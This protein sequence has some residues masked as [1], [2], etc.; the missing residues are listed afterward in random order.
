MT[1][2]WL[3]RLNDLISPLLM[4]AVL[5]LGLWLSQLFPIQWDW[6][7]RGNNSLSATSIA[8]LKRTT[9]PIDIRV[10]VAEHPGLHAQI[11]RFLQRYQQHKP[12]LTFHFVDPARH[13]NEARRQGISLSGELLLSYLSREERLQRLDEQHLTQAIQ[14]LHQ[15][16]TRWI[17]GLSGHGE[18]SLI[19]EA[20]HDLGDFGKQL[21]QQ[22]Y[23]VVEL[24]LAS[25]P[26]PPE[27]T[28]LLVIASPLKSLM[29]GE[30]AQVKNYLNRGKNLLLL[31]DTDNPT[32]QQ[33]LLDLLGIQQLPG[34]I[35]DA[36]V[37]ELGIDNPAVALVSNYPEH[38]ATRGFDFISLFPQAAA[39]TATES[40][41][42]QITPLLQ[43]L[44]RSWNETGPLMGEIQRNQELGEQSGPLTIGYALQSKGQDREQRILVIGDGDFLSNSFLMNAGNLDLG[45]ALVRWLTTDDHMLG[46][47]TKEP[48]DRELHLSPLLQGI[49]GLG[50]LIVIPSL[51]LITGGIITWRRNRA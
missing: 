10:Y 6:T 41:I 37:R 49:I 25:S 50:W 40:E 38:A 45:L 48:K 3:Q 12:D 46:I 9:G 31:V 34:T 35:V 22:G 28:S 24:D 5:I 20:N 1:S 4:L 23:Q 2:R 32:T 16:H 47:P 7:H 14:R 42:W 19:G 43:T 11:S 30:L 8:V 29:D 13:P 17:A 39:L 26:S 51:L 15:T 36:N 33:P 18:R 21:S 27:N 44:G